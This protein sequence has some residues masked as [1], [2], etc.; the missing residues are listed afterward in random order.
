[1]IPATTNAEAGGTW[2]GVVFVRAPLTPP[3]SVE[4]FGGASR[5]VADSDD[6][7]VV[8]CTS[9]T[10]VAINVPTGLTPGTTAEYVQKG[11]GQVQ[12]VAGPGMT[13]FFGSAFSPNSAEQG[14]SIVVT[15]LATNEALV[16]GDLATA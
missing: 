10:A 15:I 4:S 9:G 13:L 7:K 2:T 1:V 14:S 8:Y 11:A 16:R 5:A 6:G 12:I 3:V